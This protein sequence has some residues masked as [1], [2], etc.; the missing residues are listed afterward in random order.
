MIRCSVL[1]HLS[2]ELPLL[3]EV[4][5]LRNGE[6][7]AQMPAEL[8]MEVVLRIV[9]SEEGDR[10]QAAGPTT[11]AQLPTDLRLGHDYG[12]MKTVSG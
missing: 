8:R 1:G 6:G 10:T 11:V 2:P 4:D 3:P 9:E 7:R 12:P 5:A